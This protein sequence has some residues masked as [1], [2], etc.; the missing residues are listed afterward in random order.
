MAS[1]QGLWPKRRPCQ[2]RCLFWAP[3]LFLRLHEIFMRGGMCR[4]YSSTADETKLLGLCGWE[5]HRHYEAGDL[6]VDTALCLWI[7]S[8]DALSLCLSMMQLCRL[9]QMFERSF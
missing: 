3:C 1:K 2:R 6:T 5:N 8:T 4:K 7:T 9:E